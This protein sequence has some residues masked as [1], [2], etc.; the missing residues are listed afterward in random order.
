M[1]IYYAVFGVNVA[2]AQ[3]ERLVYK[4]EAE[5]GLN[6]EQIFKIIQSNG[7]SPHAYGVRSEIE[8]FANYY[9]TP[10]DKLNAIEKELHNEALLH[11]SYELILD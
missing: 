4:V 10:I 1:L 8:Y 2:Q 5:E 6:E 11:D 9:V 3:P 7:V